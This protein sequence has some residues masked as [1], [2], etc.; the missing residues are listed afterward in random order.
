MTDVTN[1]PT[2]A[3]PDADPPG[4]TGVVAVEPIPAVE[5]RARSRPRIT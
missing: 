3:G 5:P 2:V 4:D 1:E